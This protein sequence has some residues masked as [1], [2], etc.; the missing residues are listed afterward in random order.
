MC[1]YS[2]ADHSALR[3]HE[4]ECPARASY[5]EMLWKDGLRLEDVTA[6]GNVIR[7]V[8]VLG[9]VIR[10]GRQRARSNHKWHAYGVDRLYGHRGQ[11]SRSRSRSR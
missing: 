5:V 4:A 2:S 9:N 11:R 8:N 10:G 6:F 3:A 1:K 7:D